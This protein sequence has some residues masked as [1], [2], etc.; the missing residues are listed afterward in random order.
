MRCLRCAGATQEP[1]VDAGWTA[2]MNDMPESTLRGT[3]GGATWAFVLSLR[4]DIGSVCVGS[5]AWKAV[6]D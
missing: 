3:T 5:G 6:Y 4:S 2:D 1:F